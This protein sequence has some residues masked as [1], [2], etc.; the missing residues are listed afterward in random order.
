VLTHAVHTSNRPTM[1]SSENPG[2]VTR[3]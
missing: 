3:N 2:P 1:F